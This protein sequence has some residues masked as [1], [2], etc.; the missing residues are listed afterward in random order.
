VKVLGSLMLLLWPLRWKKKTG[1]SKN[2]END[3]AGWSSSIVF[4]HSPQ[5]L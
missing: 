5:M 3:A 2:F 4:R 1:G